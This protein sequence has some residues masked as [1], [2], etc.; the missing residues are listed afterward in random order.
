MVFW[1]YTRGIRSMNASFFLYS[2]T[3]YL[4]FAI[5]DNRILKWRLILGRK[6]DSNNEISLSKDSTQIDLVLES[7]Y[8]KKPKVGLGNSSPRINR[9]LGDIRKYFPISVVQLMQKDALERL[10]LTQMLLEPELLE[11]VIPDVHLVAT[12]LSLNK[13]MPEHTRETAK[14]VVR[15][16][17]EELEQKLCNPMRQAVNGSLNRSVRNYR[18]KWNEINWQA[19]IR[20]NLKHYQKDYKTII[21]ERLIGY[22][23]KNQELRHIILLQDQSGSMGT[24]VVYAGIMACVLASLRSVKTNML[25]F[26]TNVVDVTEHLSDP[27]DLLFAT[28]LGGGTDI[29]QA[30]KYVE[31]LIQNPEE[32]ILVLISDLYE[33]G[34]QAEMLHRVSRLKNSGVQFI[35]LLALND[36]GAPA[37]DTEVATQF[38]GMGINAFACTPDEFPDVMGKALSKR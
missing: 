31:G 16:V 2:I 27:V 38:A 3:I 8:S 13:A 22:G 12:L 11:T 26:D 30:L 6:A 35:S 21:P 33:G 36:E 19:T 23:R 18:P 20:A 7:L 9:W 32:T 34:N 5:M 29:N 10:D 1:G 37:Y 15:K 24:S 17:V 14:M 25:V 4:H 28:E